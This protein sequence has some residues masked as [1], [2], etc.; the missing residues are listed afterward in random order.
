M[1]GQAKIQLTAKNYDLTLEIP[2]LIREAD[3]VESQKPPNIILNF[4]FQKQ[5]PFY[6]EFWD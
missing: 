3:Q 2:E 6:I 1:C 5:Y 4:Q